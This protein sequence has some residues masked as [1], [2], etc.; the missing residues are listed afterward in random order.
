MAGKERFT[1]LILMR[2][3]VSLERRA[4]R[5][6]QRTPA[7]FSTLTSLSRTSDIRTR[8]WKGA[9]NGKDLSGRDRERR[10]ERRERREKQD[11]D[12]RESKGGNER[13]QMRAYRAG[14]FFGRFPYIGF[15][16]TAFARQP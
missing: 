2:L 4:S 1:V 10:R 8:P 13:G 16:T 14:W 6:R 11:K 12:G 9:S 5:K 15:R 7:S 3:P